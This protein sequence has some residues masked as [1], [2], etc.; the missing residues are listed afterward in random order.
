MIHVC[1]GL[2]DETER[3]SKFTGTAMLSIFENTNS[4]ITVHILHDNTLTQD[5]HDKF[6]YL[7]GQYGQLVKFYNVNEL[8]ADRIET[9]YKFF[10]KL[11]K[12]VFPLPCAIVFLYQSFFQLK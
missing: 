1:F 6:I 5:N 4:K 9:I 8:C 11:I 7:A 12:H 10:P 3:Y 2:H